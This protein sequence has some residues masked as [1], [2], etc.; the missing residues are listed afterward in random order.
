M[1]PILLLLSIP[2]K[3]CEP[4]SPAASVDSLSVKTVEESARIGGYGD[5]KSAK[6]RKR[7]LLIDTLGLPIATYV[8][9]AD[10]QDTVGARKLL[11]GLALCVPRLKT[12]WG[13]A[14]YRGKGLADW[15]QQQ[16]KGWE[17]EVVERKSSTHGLGIPPR[18]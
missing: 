11:G 16:G 6:G 17:L 5:H 9:P 4:A 1:S 13:D 14:A 7:H 10:I 12:I 3:L 8:T 18:R 15:C 2:C